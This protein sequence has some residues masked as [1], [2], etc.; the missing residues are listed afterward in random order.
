MRT[1]RALV[2]PL[3]LHQG[4][5]DEVLLIFGLPVVLFVILRWLGLRRARNE[6]GEG[7]PE[8]A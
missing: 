1:R 8:D 2:A 3:L 7:P 5:W 4:G 6:D